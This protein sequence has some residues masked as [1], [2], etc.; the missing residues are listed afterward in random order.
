MWLRPPVLA[1]PWVTLDTSLTTDCSMATPHRLGE[2]PMGYE[3]ETV[4]WTLLNQH[5]W[6]AVY[7]DRRE[8]CAVHSRTDRKVC[9][10]YPLSLISHSGC[11]Q[12]FI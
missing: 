8:R 10:P 11:F 9:F 2:D 5:R 7:L 4:E 12:L 6:E 1:Q 3:W